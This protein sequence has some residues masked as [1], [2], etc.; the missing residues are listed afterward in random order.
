MKKDCLSLYHLSI[1]RTLTVSVSR[2]LCPAISLTLSPVL[3][4]PLSLSGYIHIWTSFTVHPP[5]PLFPSDPQVNHVRAASDTV[6][7]TVLFAV[8]MVLND[9]YFYGFT[10]SHSG[11]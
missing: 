2:F 1:A 7:Y 3:H 11:G 6:L 8:H 4:P 5:Y 9:L 10:L